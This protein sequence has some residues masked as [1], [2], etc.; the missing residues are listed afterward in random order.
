MSEQT[1]VE[2]KKFLLISLQ[3][4]NELLNGNKTV[5]DSQISTSTTK[6]YLLSHSN[7]N[8]ETDVAAQLSVAATLNQV[9]KPGGS[10]QETD[11][12][13]AR[14]H[15]QNNLS[16]DEANE[17]VEQL[18]STGLSSGKIEKS[19]AIIKLL[20]KSE[21]IAIDKQTGKLQNKS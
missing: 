5:Q 1:K 17:I 11:E 10:N 19:K 8:N 15:Q 18:L 21:T 9:P 7:K 20:Q 16:S 3:T 4:Y 12:M 2:A 14:E 13:I 6:E